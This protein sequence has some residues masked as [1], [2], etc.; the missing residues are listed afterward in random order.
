MSTRSSADAD[1]PAQR[2][3]GTAKI[4]A[5]GSPELKAMAWTLYCPKSVFIRTLKQTET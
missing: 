5:I 2:D 3:G 4:S 1:K